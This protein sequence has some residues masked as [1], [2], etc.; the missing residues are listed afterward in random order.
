MDGDGRGV[1]WDGNRSRHGVDGGVFF[2]VCR[3][4]SREPSSAQISDS[5]TYKNWL[6]QT[7]D[8]VQIKHVY[9]H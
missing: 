8:Y 4:I 5:G 3:S 9:C 7:I 6:G 2:L 1:G